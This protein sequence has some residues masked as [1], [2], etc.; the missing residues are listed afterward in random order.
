MIHNCTYG[1]A[2]KILMLVAFVGFLFA[3]L[4][5][6]ADA[7]E[8]Y[9]LSSMD[10]D[11][12]YDPEPV[13]SAQ[14][15]AAQNASDTV[16]RLKNGWAGSIPDYYAGA[17]LDCNQLYIM[18]TEQNDSVLQE[19]DRL[20]GD[21]TYTL[22]PASH[23]YNELIALYNQ[24][25]KNMMQEGDKN[26]VLKR[27]SDWCIVERENCVLLGIHATEQEISDEAVLDALNCDKSSLCICRSQEACAFQN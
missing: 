13:P 27:I 22:V 24:I 18:V 17:Y 11:L 19:L 2:F 8:E 20:I 23:S 25:N 6:S 10:S 3:I 4:T 7:K 1:R 14:M 9:D 12:Y 5:P 26:P 15:S 21:S 16:A